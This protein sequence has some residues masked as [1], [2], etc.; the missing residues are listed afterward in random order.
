[1]KR[2][3]VY[4]LASK[5]NGVL[6]VGMTGNL[7]M[8]MKAHKEH[9]VEGFTE[10]YFVHKLVY[11]EVFDSVY[12]A[13]TREKQIKKWKRDWKIRAINEMNPEWEDLSE[14]DGFFL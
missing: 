9:A 5:R 6:Y 3:Y 8:R 10:K 13:I 4:I 14:K 2:Y 12:N 11:L 7:P 1:M